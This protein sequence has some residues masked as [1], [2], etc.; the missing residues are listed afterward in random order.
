MD[1]FNDVLKSFAK[2]HRHFED[3]LSVDRLESHEL[4]S[5]DES[6]AFV[7]HTRYFTSRRNSGFAIQ[8]P[9]GPGVDPNGDLENLKGDTHIHTLD[10]MVQYLGRKEADDGSVLSCVI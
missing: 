3:T 9:F 10:N 2:I 8:I 1:Y 7:C 5:M 4:V 6:V